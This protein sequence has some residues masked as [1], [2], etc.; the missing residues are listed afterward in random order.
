MNDDDFLRENL[1][2]IS[3]QARPVEFLDRSLARSKRIGRNRAI[4]SSAAVVVVLAV[5]GGIV[6]QVGRPNVNQPTPALGASATPSD[7]PS[8]SLSPTPS[9]VPSSPPAAELTG[10]FYFTDL[11]RVLRGRAT[12]LSAGGYTANVSP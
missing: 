9:N 3:E 12:I 10:Q 7:S 5:T 11:D 1:A 2:Q 8:P 6:W 4:L